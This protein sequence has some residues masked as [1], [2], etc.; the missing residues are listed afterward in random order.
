MSSFL[1]LIAACIFFVF[2][3]LMSYAFI[4]Y[5]LIKQKSYKML[6]KWW[7]SFPLI[8]IFSFFMALNYNLHVRCV[9][10]QHGNA[11]IFSFDRNEEL[12]IK[13]SIFSRIWRVS[14]Q[15]LHRKKAILWFSF[16]ALG[17]TTDRAA[18]IG[19]HEGG[20]LDRPWIKHEPMV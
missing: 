4:L 13:S 16:I 14:L 15:Y 18:S 11:A 5:L 1:F 12:T 10:Q 9:G 19:W 3:A 2:G 7:E 20:T 6:V 17:S 8:P